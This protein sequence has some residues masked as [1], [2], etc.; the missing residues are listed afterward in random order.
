[1]HQVLAEV[2]ADQTE[3]RGNGENEEKIEIL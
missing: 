3:M 1:M 2:E